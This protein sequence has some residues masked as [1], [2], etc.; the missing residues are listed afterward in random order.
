M[1][2]PLRIGIVGG[3]IG[4]L[5]VAVLLCELGHDVV[6]FERS[7]SALEGR[8]AGI[9]VLPM[10]ER[11]FVERGGQLGDDS[12]SRVA[13]TLTNWS[14]VNHD[15]DLI[16]EAPTNNRFTAWNTLY[17]AL[18]AVLSEDRYR[19]DHEVTDVRHIS[20]EVVISFAGGGS[21]TCDLVVAADGMGS[22]VRNIVSPET[23]TT[24]AGYV[25]WRGTVHERDLSPETA[26]LLDDAMVYQVLDH[27][28][29]LAY[30]PNTVVKD[31]CAGRSRRK[32]RQVDCSLAGI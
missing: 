5:T 1:S 26:A 2:Q 3:S 11:Y 8:G 21:H 6:V 32:K 17:R 30:V 19:L 22:T 14:Y 31:V 12:A 13:L 24:Y 15:G 9:V 27:S 20:D 10:T 29:I 23:S 28:H 18:L 7:T 16:D 4:G 25:A